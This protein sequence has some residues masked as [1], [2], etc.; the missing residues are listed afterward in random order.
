MVCEENTWKEEYVPEPVITFKAKTRVN[1]WPLTS[2]RALVRGLEDIGYVVTQGKDAVDLVAKADA[3]LSTALEDLEKN[4]THTSID[5]T[6]LTQSLIANVEQAADEL[7]AA[8]E[9]A[10]SARP[11]K[12]L[13]KST[14]RGRDFELALKSGSYVVQYEEE[15]VFKDGVLDEV[16][17]DTEARGFVTN[18]TRTYSTAQ[19]AHKKLVSNESEVLESIGDEMGARLKRAMR[20]MEQWQKVIENSEIRELVAQ[21]RSFIEAEA[22]NLGHSV[23]IYDSVE[24]VC[25]VISDGGRQLEELR[26][27]QKENAQV[28]VGA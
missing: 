13:A 3:R 10:G 23:E 19:E 12:I 1:A 15:E 5:G 27:L 18:L 4:S 11:E 16:L 17:E 22:R 21:R 25:F 28:S 20:S 14:T 2:I 24:R 6:E 8:Q 9:A 26:Q 7:R